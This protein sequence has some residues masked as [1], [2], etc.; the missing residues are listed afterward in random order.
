MEYLTVAE[1]AEKLKV[2]ERTI[3]DWIKLEGLPAARIGREYRIPA[4]KLDEWV[5]NRIQKR[6]VI[7]LKGV[8]GAEPFYKIDEE[9]RHIILELL[10]KAQELRL[11]NVSFF[12]YPAPGSE[13]VEFCINEN[14]DSWKVTVKQNRARDIYKV[15]DGVIT[16]NCSEQE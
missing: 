16:Y 1:V 14:R 9:T 5:K 7:L 11:G 3:R 4:D 15:I 12:Y 8:E 13:E 2:T 10:N 6:K